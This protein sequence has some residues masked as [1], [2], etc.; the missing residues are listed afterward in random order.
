[1]GEDGVGW[2]EDSLMG[3][4]ECV[5]GGGCECVMGGGWCVMGR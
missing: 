1:M 3:G 2:G 5:M 4:C